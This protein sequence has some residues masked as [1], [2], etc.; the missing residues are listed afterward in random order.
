MQAEIRL[1]F[2][3]EIPFDIDFRAKKLGAGFFHN[4][5]EHT[6]VQNALA[7]QKDLVMRSS[8]RKTMT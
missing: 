6:D 3:P 7:C 5:S 2:L 8:F 4:S 1:F